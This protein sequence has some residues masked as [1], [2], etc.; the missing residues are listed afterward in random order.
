MAWQTAVKPCSRCIPSIEDRIIPDAF[1]D[2]GVC[3]TGTYLDS[4]INYVSVGLE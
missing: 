1:L 2:M 3:G 4:G